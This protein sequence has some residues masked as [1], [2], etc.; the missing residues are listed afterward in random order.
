MLPAAFY[1]FQPGQRCRRLKYR[2]VI[3][4]GGRIE[5]W[6]PINQLTAIKSTAYATIPPANIP[7]STPL[8]P[9]DDS[10]NGYQHT[11]AL[12]GPTIFAITRLLSMRRGRFSRAGF[13]RNVTKRNKS[14]RPNTP[15]ICQTC[16]NQP[17]VQT[18]DPR[19]FCALSRATRRHEW[20]ETRDPRAP[21]RFLKRAHY[22]RTRATRPQNV[23]VSPVSPTKIA[24][25]FNSQKTKRN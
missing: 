22:A 13:A 15:S 25:A 2:K 23:T 4:P 21:G 5:I 17:A 18:R 19:P 11:H 8:I 24:A 6:D 12:T 9:H 16:A 20:L 14:G 1:A 3:A 10:E 7:V